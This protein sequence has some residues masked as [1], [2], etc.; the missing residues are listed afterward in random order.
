MRQ[1]IHRIYISFY[2][3]IILG[4]LGGLILYGAN[5]YSTQIDERYFHEQHELL[6]PTGLIGHGLGILG[7][8]FILFGVFSYMVRKRIR[9]FSKVGLLKYWLE[10]HIFLCTLGP[11]LILFHTSFKFG[12]LV[13]ASFW[14][15]AAV[16]ASGV[17]GRFIYLQIPRS[18]GGRELS[19]EELNTLKTGLL[20]DLTNKYNLDVEMVAFLSDALTQ[21]T[22]YPERNP[23]IRLYQR[24]RSEKRLLKEMKVKLKAHKIPSSDFKGVNKTIKRE[25]VLTRKIDWLWF[26]Q[27]IFRYWHVAHLP[28]A[29]VMLAIMVV[30]IIVA[31]LFGYNWIF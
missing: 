4:T 24:L 19:R 14:S 11:V 9:R 20:A 30:H 6:K 5:Y 3:L 15:M 16:V 28:F 12:G 10:F 23:I 2:V 18:I 13:A 21:K 25:I 26:M 17:I 1:S 31:I 8:F 29:F 27:R 7:S 22:I